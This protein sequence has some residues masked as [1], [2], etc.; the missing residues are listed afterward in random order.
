M[1]INTSGKVDIDRNRSFEEFIVLFI[2]QAT[3]AKI[4]LKW[5]NFHTFKQ[6]YYISSQLDLVSKKYKE[7]RNKNI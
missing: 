6:H 3:S 2:Q 7:E 4:L 1:D 5:V